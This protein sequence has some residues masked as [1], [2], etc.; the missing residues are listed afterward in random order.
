MPEIGVPGTP[1]GPSP[2]R[3]AIGELVVTFYEGGPPS[4]QWPNIEGRTHRQVVGEATT[5]LVNLL[6]GSTLD[7]LVGDPPREPPF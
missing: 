1:D 4:I 3:P 2:E 5:A 7:K 6:N